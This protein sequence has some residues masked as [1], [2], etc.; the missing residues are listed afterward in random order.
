M[1]ERLVK[2]PPQ[3]FQA[4]P[5]VGHG[6]RRPVPTQ[7]PPG[8]QQTLRG[9][10]GKKLIHEPNPGEP[11]PRDTGEPRPWDTGEP[12]P[13]EPRPG[14]PGPGGAGTGDVGPPRSPPWPNPGEPGPRDTGE[15]RPRD[16]G[17]PRPG[18][19]GPRNTG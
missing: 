2:R 4:L 13:G 8:R 10:R 16:T 14:E 1:L 7:Q 15:P 3:G 6:G 17:E 11:G 18:E 9:P 5:T 19:P 12:R